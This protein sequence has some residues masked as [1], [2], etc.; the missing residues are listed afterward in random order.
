VTSTYT[1]VPRELQ[2]ATI[3][4]KDVRSFIIREDRHVGPR[5]EFVDKQQLYRDLD[6]CLHR[7]K[8]HAS[9]VPVVLYGTK[10]GDNWVY[11]GGN[12]RVTQIEA[13]MLF[14]TG[15]YHFCHAEDGCSVDVALSK[16]QSQHM[17][18][19]LHGIGD[20][21][22][23]GQENDSTARA[24]GWQHNKGRRVAARGAHLY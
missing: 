7:T 9:E 24:G 6:V 12:I 15:C 13:P 8:L 18:V 22:K 17:M 5:K 11:A 10:T 1:W 14:S 21:L 3:Q 23:P 19:P 2:Q 4:Q 20:R 16:A